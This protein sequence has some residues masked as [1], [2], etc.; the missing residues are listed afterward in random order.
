MKNGQNTLKDQ[1]GGDHYRS[2]TIQPIEYIQANNLGYEEGN[3]VKYATRHGD[4]GQADDIKKLIQYAA[5]IL[6]HEYGVVAT[7]AYE[8]EKDRVHIDLVDMANEYFDT[9]IQG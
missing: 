5:F 3:I 6:E 8:T 9:L 4:K 1:V 7:V 2:Q